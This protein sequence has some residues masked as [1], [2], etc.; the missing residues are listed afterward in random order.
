MAWLAEMGICVSAGTIKVGQEYFSS[1]SHF[2]LRPIEY[3]H[4]SGAAISWWKGYHP[5]G[6]SGAS[7][8]NCRIYSDSSIVHLV[9]IDVYMGKIWLDGHRMPVRTGWGLGEWLNLCLY[10]IRLRII[11][12]SYDGSSTSYAGKSHP[13]SLV[14]LFTKVNI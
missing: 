9:E 12:L 4:T 13:K 1:F 11:W 7:K 8:R 14:S 2:G 10:W 5:N 6:T 3:R